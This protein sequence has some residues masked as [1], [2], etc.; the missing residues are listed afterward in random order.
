MMAIPWTPADITTAL[1]L[2][3]NDGDTVTLDG[4]G[5]CQ[6]LDDKS[7]NDRHMTFNSNPAIGSDPGGQHLVFT[8]GSQQ[9]D[10]PSLGVSGSQNRSLIMALDVES[11]SNGM[12]CMNTGGGTGLRWT[13]RNSGGLRIELQGSG[14]T[15]ALSGDGAGVYGVI[16]DGST[17]GDHT[18]Y[19][20]G[21]SESAS[22]GNS[23]NT[24]DQDNAVAANGPGTDNLN[25][26]FREAIF[27]AE[28]LD[29]ATWQTLEGYLAHKWDGI[30]G[31]T[32]RVDALDSGHPYKDS[33]PTAPSITGNA[34]F[35]AGYAARRVRLL[36][37]GGAVVDTATPEQSGGTI[38][39]YEIRKETG[40]IQL[41]AHAFDPQNW[42]GIWQPST[43]YAEG[44][45]VFSNGDTGADSLAL[46]C[47][48]TSGT[49]ESGGTEPTWDATEGNTTA[50][51]DLTWT[52]LGTVGDLSPITNF[53]VAE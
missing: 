5:D 26:K 51:N 16:F 1:W 41:Q 49:G 27:V 28:A 53:Y 10:L 33:P 8:G 43:A 3:A 40:P 37:P 36:E 18:L 34:L 32:T 44:D 45:I 12:F 4:G 29:T 30:T 31:T 13:L 14:Y 20:D 39:D 25:G 6:Q 22:G 24:T 2:D 50:D 17:L 21:A 9:G 19:R 15:S 35:R 7:G 38:G 11:G 23:V 46:E 52:T 42:R 47:T 48:A